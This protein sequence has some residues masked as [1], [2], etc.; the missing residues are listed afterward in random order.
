MS[1][2][3]DRLKEYLSETKTTSTNSK[4][5]SANV[6][7]NSFMNFFKKPSVQVNANG[8]SGTGDQAETDSW[9]REAESDPYCPKL[10]GI[11]RFVLGWFCMS[12]ISQGVLEFS[13]QFDSKPTQTRLNDTTCFNYFRFSSQKSNA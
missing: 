9:F 13:C 8:A 10:V 3:Y 7:I 2:D 1:A 6:S 11:L 12:L 4:F 5:P